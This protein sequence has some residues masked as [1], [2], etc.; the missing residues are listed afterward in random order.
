M[1]KGRSDLATVVKKLGGPDRAAE[2][3]RLTWMPER[4]RERFI[5]SQ[6]AEALSAATQPALTHLKVGP[7]EVQRVIVNLLSRGKQFLVE[8]SESN[9]E[10]STTYW[11]MWYTPL[12]TSEFNSPSE[13]LQKLLVEAHRCSQTHR[14]H[15]VRIMA[16]DPVTQSQLSSFVLFRPT[17]PTQPSKFSSK[18][19]YHAARA[20]S[21]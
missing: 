8:H 7:H 6:V 12:S 17:A 15:F 11:R 13:G 19:F 2:G 10:S 18:P 5:Q 1:S 16:F 14:N 4:E 21:S 20:P 3:M 9:V